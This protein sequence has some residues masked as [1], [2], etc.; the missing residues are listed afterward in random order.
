MRLQRQRRG[1]NRGARAQVG[2]LRHLEIR[3]AARVDALKG[4]K[5]HV[6]VESKSVIRGTAPDADTKTC[7]LCACDVDT[8][9]IA[10]AFGVDAPLARVVYDARLE[11]ADEVAHRQRRALQVNER[12]DDELSGTVIGHLPA[13][14]DLQ[15][16][17]IPR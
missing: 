16:R 5:I 4:R 14:I 3:I 10:A 6:D 12:I 15:N 8:R 11:S 2:K 1:G 17:N 9:R 13:A 7:K